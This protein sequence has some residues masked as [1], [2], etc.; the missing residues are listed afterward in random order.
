MYAIR[1]Y[2]VLHY[3]SVIFMSDPKNVVFKE[4][5]DLSGIYIEGPDFDKSI[6]LKSYNFV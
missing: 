3:F 2:Y 4:S 1:S 5:E 6:D